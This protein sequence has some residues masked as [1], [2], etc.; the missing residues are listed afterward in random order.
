M[1][2]LLKVFDKSKP[3]SMSSPGPATEPDTPEPDTPTQ[4]NFQLFQET[5]RIANVPRLTLSVKIVSCLFGICC[6]GI[7][8][9]FDSCL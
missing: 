3:D 7:L 5:P 9:G 2:I 4:V 8:E 1:K 6:N